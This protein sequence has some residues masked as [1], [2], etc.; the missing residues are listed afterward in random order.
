MNPYLVSM[1]AMRFISSMIEFCAALLF[2]HSR[3][4]ETALRINALLGLVGP[5]VF[6]GVSFLGI[7]AV[8]GNVSFA[9]LVVILTG[10]VLVLIGTASK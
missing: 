6:A 10:V 2:L 3:E 9:K 4:V 1:A 5:V 8:A 7:C